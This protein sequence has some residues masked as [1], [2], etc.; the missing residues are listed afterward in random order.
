MIDLHCHILPALDDGA[1]DLDDAV[2]M[3]RQAAA[4]GIGVIC[5]TPHIRHDHDVAIGELPGR[6]SELAAELGRRGVDVRLATGAEVAESAVAGLDDRELLAASLGGSG[7][8]ILLEPAPGPLS[9]SLDA[10]VGEL[11]SRGFRSVIAHPERHAH[12]DL[13]GH[14]ARLVEQG[15]LVQVTAAFLEHEHAAPV[16]VDLAD[17]GLVHVLGS[18]AHSSRGGRPVVLSR[19]LAALRAAPSLANHLDWVAGA[20]PA[21]I[22]AGEDVRPP[23]GTAV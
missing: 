8:W 10:A 1:L 15:A 2:E 6:V 14:L 18:D 9:Q 22:L 19:G 16:I 7:R 11:D 20:A 23:F 5:A 3:A 4:D 13:R 12:A 21:A 17:H